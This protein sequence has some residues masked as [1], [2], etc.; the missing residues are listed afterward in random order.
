MI[1]GPSDV[2][3]G[4]PQND[5]EHTVIDVARIDYWAASGTGPLHRTSTIS[6]VIF[7]LMAVSAAIVARSPYSLMAGYCILVAIAAVSELPWIKL[8][9]LFLF[10]ASSI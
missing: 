4:A 7:V 6:K 5:E 2:A 1:T 9:L 10:H 3:G 8:I